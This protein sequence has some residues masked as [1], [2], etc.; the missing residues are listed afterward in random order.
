[1]KRVW[2]MVSNMISSWRAL[3][4][5]S[6]LAF[7]LAGCGGGVQYESWPGMTLV[8]GTLYVSMVDRI[9]A[10]DAETGNP[11]WSYP[12]EPDAN[13]G[14]Y[15]A[16]TIDEERG[17]MF[18]AGFSDQKVHAL[19]LAENPENMPTPLWT[20]PPE[21][22]NGGAKGQYVGSGTI[23][24]NLFLVGNGDGLIYA[25]RLE[26]GS[27]A[28]SFE[29]GDRIWA[30]P[31]VQDDTVYVASLDDYL[32]ALN[33]DDGS[34]RWR[35]ETRGALGASPVL[36]DSHIWLGDFGDQIYQ[37]DPQTGEVLWTFEDGED[38]FWATP[39]VGEDAIYFSDVRGNVFAFDIASRGLLWKQS[40]ADVIRGQSV[41]NADGTHLLVPGHEH[42][43][44]YALDTETGEEVP[45]G[46]VPE[47]PGRLPGNLV[48]DT[49]RVYAAPIM[50]PTRV[51]GFDIQDGRLL[52]VYPVAQE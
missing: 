15:A 20:Y 40:V 19:R 50:I 21:E 24:Q 27:L 12:V 36:A 44:I 6:L 8:D 3:V 5:V 7:L 26:D 45:W 47:G 28:W 30:Q 35:L 4:W 13:I 32:Y 43:V 1:M 2:R 39:T 16:P 48:A 37:I 9:Q 41:L 46:I 34:E 38:W 14:F 22:T 29:T 23:A 31:L 17:L 10:F 11:L 49:E 52:W 42:G 51:Q 25:L 18:A 33:L